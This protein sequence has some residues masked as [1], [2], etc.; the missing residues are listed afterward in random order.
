LSALENVTE[1]RYFGTTLADQNKSRA[2]KIRYN[3]AWVWLETRKWG[4]EMC[5]RF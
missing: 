3:A 2:D 4:R 5:A 1:V